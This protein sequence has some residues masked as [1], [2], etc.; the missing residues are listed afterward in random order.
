MP[1]FL[2]NLPVLQTF[3]YLGQLFKLIALGHKIDTIS[4]Q[5]TTFTEVVLEEQEK[6]GEE[7]MDKEKI[8]T[9]VEE[10]KDHAQENS[11]VATAQFE[12]I[13]KAKTMKLFETF[14]ETAPQTMLQLYIIMIQNEDMSKTQIVSLVKGF[15]LFVFGAMNNYLGPTKVNINLINWKIKLNFF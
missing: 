10:L 12:I 3:S 7:T 11:N 13:D 14:L 6:Q 4:E 15:F 5:H 8:D 2:H 1:N 9:F